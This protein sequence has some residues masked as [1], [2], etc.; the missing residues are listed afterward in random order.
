MLRLFVNTLT[1]DNKYSRSNVSNFA[2]QVQTPLSQEGKYF[3]DF[4]LN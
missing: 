3:F 2:Q 1:P 4:L